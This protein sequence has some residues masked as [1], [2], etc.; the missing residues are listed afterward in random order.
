MSR[1]SES[2]EA[3]DLGEDTQR[4]LAELSSLYEAARTLLGARNHL[5]VASRIVHSGMG[6]LGARSGAM[7]VADDRGRYR[8]LHA[9]G[10]DGG[11]RGET[12]PVTAQAREWLLREGSFRLGGAGA[13]RA[14]GDLSERLSGPFDAAV[15]A[16]VSDAHG[17]QGLL[18]FG[19][20]LLPTDYD[21]DHLALLDSLASLAA[22][23]L[24]ARP[25]RDAST[26]EGVLADRRARRG[27]TRG[28]ARELEALREAYPPL[29]AMI[30]ASAAM[31]ETCQELVAVAQTPFPVLLTGESGVGKEL[32]A[33]AIHE[34]SDRAA[35]PFEVV[36][37]GS[38][39][40]DL[41]E[42]EL[43][44]HVRGAFTGAHRDRRGAFELAQ[45][46]TLFLDEVG[47]MPLPLQKRLLR[48]L[49]ERRF[50]R[51]GDEHMIEGD[52]RVVAA[53]NRD[54]HAEVN[55]KRFRED[56]YYRLTVF[57]IRIPALRERI[58]D[59]VPLMRHILAR[60]CKDLGIKAC[61]VDADVLGA[62]SEHAWPGNVRELTNL[63]AAL[64]VR[65]R[66]DGHI[67]RTDLDHVWRRQH[68]G[69]DPPWSG[70]S[71]LARGRLGEWVLVQAR[72]ARFNLIEAARL[73]QRR[74][75]SGQAVPLTERSALSYYLVG[76]ILRALA[77]SEG[78]ADA[79][80]R[81]IAGSDELTD[82]IAPRVAKICEALRS[83]RGAE[84]K[85][86]FNKLPAGYE[87]ILTRARRAVARG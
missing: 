70:V 61:E 28:P 21:D 56:L 3:T 9:A 84:L 38:I 20:R 1:R 8:L 14:L 26:P 62:L 17:L 12:V 67:T 72:A 23:C 85:R 82:R 63:C 25:A 87:D 75:R 65:A 29:K 7:F 35:G 41:I 33:H 51:V 2:P 16:A 45:R 69:Q 24:A 55:A 47:E 11:E 73:L 68:G 40:R 6:V 57:S 58:E 30:G 15:G 18:V 22:Q 13:T 52:V 78:D 42:S 60:Q 49:Q 50:R 71:R 53:T 44:G 54:L 77:E 36:D 59:L 83:V 74:K 80:S 19:P 32:A 79:A 48:V 10:V 43:F 31:L 81:A 34:L 5:Q 64:S 4:R 39:P 86:T 46:G 66:E 27:G 37:C 76:E